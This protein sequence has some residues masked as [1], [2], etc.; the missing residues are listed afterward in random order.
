MSG[1]Q[2]C[3]KEIYRRVRG[4]RQSRLDS[5]M[6]AVLYHEMFSVKEMFKQASE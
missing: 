5:D 4:W 6:V 1:A 3:Y 2:E